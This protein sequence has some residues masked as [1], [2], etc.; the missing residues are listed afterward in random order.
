VSKAGLRLSTAAMCLCTS[1]FAFAPSRAAASTQFESSGTL[2]GGGTYVVSSDPLAATA[3]I[4]LWF[5]APSAGSNNAYPGIARLALAALAASS[6]PHG[7]SLA[8]LV[9]RMGGSLSLTVY[10]DIAMV[11]VSVP[12]WDATQ[13]LRALTSAYFAPAISSEGLKSAL[14]DCAI[15]AAQGRFDSDRVM[16]DA[17][18]SELFA[19]GPAHVAPI[20]DSASAFARI[21]E[22]QVRAFAARAFRQGNAVLSIAGA[23]GTQLLADVRGAAASSSADPPYDSPLSNAP[24]SMDRSGALQGF[25]L[26]WAGAPISDQKAATALDFIADYLFD[27]DHGTFAKA[28]QAA[29]PDAFVSGQF[30]TLHNPGVLLVVVSGANTPELRAQLSDAV[31]ATKKPMDEKTFTA[32]RSAFRYHLLSQTQTPMSR[33]DNLG[34]Y[35]AEGNAAY[36]PGAG[37]GEYLNAVEALDP[38]YVAQTAR[39]YLQRPAAVQLISTGQKGTAT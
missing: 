27:S 23:A 12:F 1:L 19:A 31:A 4:E 34:W 26:A 6:P 30:I 17:L 39:T 28:V 14:R 16:Q 7:T 8:Q 2:P 24:G 11:G 33:A 36:A 9:N 22:D 3:A 20:P 15:A 18:F 37:S 35:A 32:A 21:P 10:P 38:G 25:G 29:R 5:R 13:A